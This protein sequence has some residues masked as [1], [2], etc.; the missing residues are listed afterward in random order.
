MTRPIGASA[1]KTSPPSAKVPDPL[2]GDARQRLVAAIDRL[3]LLYGVE[4]ETQSLH[5]QLSH[6]DFA[7]MLQI[8]RLAVDKAMRALEESG[9]IRSEY[10]RMT[11]VDLPALRS[12]AAF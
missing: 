10:D 12:E 6:D 3:A 2:T 8:S 4:D 7:A 1:P 9:L 11:V 5:L